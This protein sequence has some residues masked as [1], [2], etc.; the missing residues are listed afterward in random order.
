M[1]KTKELPCRVKVL[2]LSFNNLD[3]NLVC[4]TVSTERRYS[5]T[6]STQ[7]LKSD[8]PRSTQAKYCLSISAKSG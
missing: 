2:T 5:S 8:R 6:V 3:Q 7:K 1:L 4:L